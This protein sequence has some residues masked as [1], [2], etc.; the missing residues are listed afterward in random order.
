VPQSLTSQ[1]KPPAIVIGLDNMTGL[2]TARILASRQVPVIA[3]AND[4]AHFCCRTR[5]CQEIH[6]AS[7]KNEEFIGLLEEIGPQLS[8]KAVLFPCTDLSVLQISRNRERLAPWYHVALPKPEV[9]ETLVD[10]LSFIHFAWENDLPIPKT[11]FLK[12]RAEAMKAAGELVFPVIVKPPM[13]TPVWESHTKA[14][15]FKPSNAREFMELY[16]RCADWAEELMVQEFIEGPDANLYSCNCYY[17]ATAQPLVSFIAR[18][19]RQWPPETGTSCLGEEV[20]NDTVLDESLRLFS[21]VGYH[22]LGYVEMKRD[23]RTG[24]HYIIEPNIG[25]P[26]GRSAIA[27]AGGVELVYTMY[28]DKLGLPLPANRQQKYEGVKWIYLRHDFQ[29]ALHY[30]RRGELSLREWGSSLKGRKGYAIFSWSDQAP[31]WHDIAR[32]VV[33]ALNELKNRG[34]EKQSG[35]AGLETYRNKELL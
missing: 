7:T 14:K 5:V 2:Q 27:E 16:D 20:R 33:R 35:S 10:K 34:K 24:K 6:I 4:A 30:W 12:N 31:F 22:G 32:T 19:L 3:I 23:Q 18:K 13:K 11:M 28:C 25:R 17:D 8:E 26:T 21:S 15:V 1:P 9:V 29:S